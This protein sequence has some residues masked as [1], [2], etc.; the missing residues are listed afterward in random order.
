ML[1]VNTTGLIKRGRL[2]FIIKQWSYGEP[3]SL[4]VRV[5]TETLTHREEAGARVQGQR[6]T[7]HAMTRL[8]QPPSLLSVR[9]ST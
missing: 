6:A 4:H 8:V 5:D 7:P 9:P 3:K 2:N 1:H